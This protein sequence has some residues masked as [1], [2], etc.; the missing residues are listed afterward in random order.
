MQENQIQALQ[1]KLEASQ[2]KVKLL[3]EEMLKIVQGTDHTHQ[4]QLKEYS[5]KLLNAEN[6][7]RK[8][9]QHVTIIEAELNNAKERAETAEKKSQETEGK[10]EKLEKEIAFFR[11]EVSTA[12]NELQ[13][14]YEERELEKK[15]LE[16]KVVTSEEKLT[17]TTKKAS[18]LKDEL[19]KLYVRAEIAESNS[20]TAEERADRTGKEIALYRKQALNIERELQTLCEQ[21]EYERNRLELKLS[22]TEDKL[23]ETM[24]ELHAIKEEFKMLTDRAKTAESKRCTAEGSAERIEKELAQ[25][26]KKAVIVKHELQTKEVERKKLELNFLTT[27]EKLSE[28]T[29]E[30]DKLGDE[31]KKLNDRAERAEKELVE[32]TTRRKLVEGELQTLQ[33]KAVTTEEELNDVIINTKKEK[34]DFMERTQ[35]IKDKNIKLLQESAKRIQELEQRVAETEREL[36]TVNM[37]AEVKLEAANKQLNGSEEM[38]EKLQTKIHEVCSRVTEKDRE[39]LHAKNIAEK[40]KNDLATAKQVADHNEE[41]LRSLVEEANRVSMEAV[42]RAR[43]VE[44]F[45]KSLKEKINNENVGQLAKLLK[46]YEIRTSRAEAALNM[47]EKNHLSSLVEL[48]NKEN[49]IS[50]LK[51]KRNGHTK[52][53]FGHDERE[54]LWA[55]KCADASPVEAELQKLKVEV[56]SL[57]QKNCVLSNQVSS[58]CQVRHCDKQEQLVTPQ[59]LTNSLLT[60][61]NKYSFC[62]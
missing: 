14:I 4:L 59:V 43:N 48:R 54:D 40:A 44:K 51:K 27:K 25:Y 15:R 19:R 60:T 5:R 52:K 39:L 24:K 18:A 49:E 26:Q 13:T 55:T 17:E 45:A 61:L 11:K 56:T 32:E 23:S 9:R 22:I 35:Q 53:D 10:I 21:K 57:K 47:A 37:E 1:L 16:T 6:E 33:E 34:L 50:Q 7:L 3:K 46:V 29:K 38:M 30:S 20:C 36:Q 12:K 42:D 28:A 8:N 2:C 58:Y 31:C 41:A 62:R